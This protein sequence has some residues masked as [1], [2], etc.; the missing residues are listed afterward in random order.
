MRAAGL[1]EELGS[2]LDVGLGEVVGDCVGDEEGE[3]DGLFLRG[4]SFTVAFKSG[5]VVDSS[6]RAEDRLPEWILVI[7]KVCVPA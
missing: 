7:W 3:G 5:C 1:G 2:L 6:R 4:A